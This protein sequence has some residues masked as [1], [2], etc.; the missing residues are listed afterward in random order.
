MTWSLNEL[1]A[2]VKKAIKGAGLSWGL[3]E[4]GSK[5]VRWLAAH[6]ADRCRH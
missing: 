3:A 6:G 1:E 4:E 2:E 5:A